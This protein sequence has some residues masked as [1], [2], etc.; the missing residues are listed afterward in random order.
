MRARTLSGW[1]CLPLGLL[2]VAAPGQAAAG[3]GS[4]ANPVPGVRTANPLTEVLPPGKWPVVE[5]S[6]DRALAW[7]ATQQAADGSFPTLPAAQPAVT[8]LCVLAFLARG[9]QPGLGPYG[10]Q[11][12]RAI[13]FVLACQRDDG[14][15]SFEAATNTDHVDLTAIHTAV[16]NHA[17]AGLMLGEVFGH[18]TG[19]EDGGG[20]AGDDQGAPVHA[21]TA[22]PSQGPCGRS[23]G[24]A[25]SAPSLRSF[26]GG[27]RTFR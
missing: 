15:F 18:V 5:N 7:I 26:R 14:L 19:A 12:E 4:S 17:I 10:T 1:R 3:S 13:D 8:S 9:H 21:G 6:V 23:G 2:L 25:L 20:E 22:N 27:T 24:L 16:Y 11:M